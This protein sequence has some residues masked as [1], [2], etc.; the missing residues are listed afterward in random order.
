MRRERGFTLVELMVVVLIIGVLVAIAVPVF[1]VARE[2]SEQRACFANQRTIAGAAQAWA[3]QHDADV[4]DLAG[5]LTGGH[6]LMGDYVFHQP[7]RCPTAPPP[8]DVMT[9]DA[10]HGAYTLND[11]GG[12]LAC[13]Q[14][15]P[16]HGSIYDH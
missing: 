8:D 14:G 5:V 6:P 10:A 12:V 15:T 13:T 9:V 7:P 2:R 3:S 11:S 16:A 1:A 4:S